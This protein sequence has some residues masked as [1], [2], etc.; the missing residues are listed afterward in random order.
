M[1][2]IQKKMRKN[3]GSYNE[4]YHDDDHDFENENTEENDRY[5]YQ[6]DAINYLIFEGHM[7]NKTFSSIR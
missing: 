5:Q 7:I 6:E 3:R 4:K 2:M 1:E